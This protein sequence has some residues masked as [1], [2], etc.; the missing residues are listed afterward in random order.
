[1]QVNDEIH[2]DWNKKPRAAAEAGTGQQVVNSLTTWQDKAAALQRA[3][4]NACLWGHPDDVT[5]QTD[6]PYAVVKRS[7]RVACVSRLNPDPTGDGR[8]ST[9]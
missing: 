8:A 4:D 7:D 5:K 1:M 6:Q 3:V 9:L 2:T